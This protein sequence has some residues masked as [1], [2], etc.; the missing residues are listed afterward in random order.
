[1][2]F[3]ST[4]L[5]NA[6]IVLTAIGECRIFRSLENDSCVGRSIELLY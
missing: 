6:E 5:L 1:M 4:L 2:S 3:F